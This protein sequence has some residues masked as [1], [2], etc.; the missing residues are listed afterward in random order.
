MNETIETIKN[1]RSV[2]NYSSE[3]IKDEELE[4][5]IKTAIYAPT[6]HNTNHGI[7]P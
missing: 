5:K 1:R 6:G 7:L 2:R 3:Q 4:K